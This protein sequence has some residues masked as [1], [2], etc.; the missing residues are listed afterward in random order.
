[1]AE[2]RPYRQRGA[3]PAAALD[4]VTVPVSVPA[5]S[6][7][8]WS[9]QALQDALQLIVEGLTELVGFGRA[10]MNVRRGDDLVVVA[11]AGVDRARRPDGTVEDAGAMLGTRWPVD[12]VEEMLEHAEDWGWFKFLP[13]GRVARSNWG[14]LGEDACVEGEDGWHPE[15]GALAPIQDDTGRLVGAISVDGP[16]TGRYPDAAQRRVMDRHASQTAEVLLSALAR[17]ALERRLRL[18]EGARQLVR[19]ASR[20]VPL[21]RMLDETGPAFLEAFAAAGLWLRIQGSS[22]AIVAGTR[23]RLPV[24]LPSEELAAAVTSAAELLWEQGRTGIVRIEGDPSDTVLEE[25]HHEIIRELLRARGLS[26]VLH[27]P[28]G[29]GAECLGSLILARA[30]GQ[31]EWS[32][33]ERDQAAEVGR[34]LGRVIRNEQT[35]ARLQG[36]VRELRAVDAHKS[37]L[38][39]M[40]SH[41][42]KNPLTVL[43]ANRDLLELDLAGERDAL[44]RL[45]DM[46]ANAQRMN[47]VVENLLLLSK[48]ADPDTPLIEHDVDLGRLLDEAGRLLP[49]SPSSP[50]SG[51]S[52]RITTPDEPLVVRGDAGELRTMLA[53]LVENAVKFSNPGG[54]VE[55]SATVSAGRAEVVVADHGIGISA[56]DQEQ[57][58]TDFFRSEDPTAASR[59]GSG[60]GLAIVERILRRHHGLAEIT[61]ALGEGTTVRVRLPL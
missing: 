15:D 8:A 50:P 48:L 54:R 25:P 52:L 20:H 24:T 23:D 4:P 30:Q 55:L 60:L 34:D 18:A 1:M 61:S 53:N 56:E 46:D 16:R 39:A 19:T 28:I 5:H 7:A 37:H 17:E 47:A 3:A 22:G 32:G 59:P 44:A 21:D 41:E 51:V 38:I 58:F 49:A 6:A 35:Y 33:V 45:A 43:A 27:A 2:P 57:L 11:V 29:A 31:P 12:Q 36:V 40:F 14:W 10:V 42:L 9:E 13:H 26:S